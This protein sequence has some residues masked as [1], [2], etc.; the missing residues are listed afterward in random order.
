MRF[1]N[2]LGLIAG[3]VFLVWLAVD[4]PGE[5]IGIAMLGGFAVGLGI[6]IGIGIL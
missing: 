4:I 5:Q 3:G 6:V 2:S 1:L